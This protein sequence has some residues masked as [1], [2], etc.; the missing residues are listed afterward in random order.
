MTP[1]SDPFVSIVVPTRNRM[2]L[3]R[4]CLESLLSQDYP[5]DRYEIII[6]DDGSRDETAAVVSEFARRSIV[7]PVRLVAQP[8][9]GL[10]AAR[11]TGIT[12]ARGDPICFVDDDVEA[13][14]GWLSAMVGGADRYPGAGCLGG[15]VRVRLEGKAPRLCGREPGW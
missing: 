14:K 2:G 12:A 7:P 5:V 9:R 11:N 1:P 4:S 6:V 10:N 15:P 13:P 8:P 3:L